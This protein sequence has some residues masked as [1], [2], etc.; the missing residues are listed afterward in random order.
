MCHPFLVSEFQKLIWFD[1]ERI[2]NAEQQVE[3][4]TDRSVFDFTQMRLL[5]AYFLG[6]SILGIMSIFSII[7]N[8]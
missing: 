8:I 3:R 5:N 7:R 4:D 1:F 2:R 6:K